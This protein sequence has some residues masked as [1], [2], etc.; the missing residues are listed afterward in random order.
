MAKKIVITSGKGGVGKTSVTANLGIFLSKMG[1]KIALFDVDFGLNNLDVVLGIEKKVVFD[2]SD[3]LD[4]RCRLKQALIQHEF[5]KNLYVL[6][7]D[8]INSLSNLSG[9]N[10]KL[11]LEKFSYS[12]DYILIDCPA[13]IDLGFHRAVSCA[14]QVLVVVTPD[15]TSIRDAS[16]VLSIIKSYKPEYSGLIINKVRGDLIVGN[17]SVHPIEISR[18]LKT[19][20]LGVLP[21]DDDIMF[22]YDRGLPKKSNSYKAYRILTD[23]FLSGK[24]KIFDTCN[25]YTGFFGSIRRGIKSNI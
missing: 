11:I 21:D 25:K 17:K 3:V 10:L 20:L 12:F 19:E 9:Q 13:G 24:R 14:D 1:K 23:N 22:L 4:G 5:Y 18:I 2:V 7:S 6:P 15:S 16:K 8:K